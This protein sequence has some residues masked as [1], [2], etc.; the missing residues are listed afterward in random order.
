[1]VHCG[2]ICAMPPALPKRLTQHTASGIRLIYFV[3]NI[4]DEILL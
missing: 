2:H 4:H 3:S 1:M